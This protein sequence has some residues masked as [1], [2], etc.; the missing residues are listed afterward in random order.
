MWCTSGTGTP[1]G[2]SCLMY[3][4]RPRKSILLAGPVC[5]RYVAME[6][7]SVQGDRALL[8]RACVDSEAPVCLRGRRGALG[9]IVGD[10]QQGVVP[11]ILASSSKRALPIDHVIIT[12]FHL[13]DSARTTRPKYPLNAFFG[14][15][16]YGPSI[17]A[18]VSLS[19][20]SPNP[21]VQRGA[22]DLAYGVTTSD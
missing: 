22:S 11:N 17:T 19:L 7:S 21:D 4:V 12:P 10:Q 16:A 1:A 6:R 9:M 13:P 5:H 18:A 15:M 3:E 2:R 8:I 20:R 14:P